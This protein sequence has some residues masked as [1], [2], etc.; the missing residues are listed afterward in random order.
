MSRLACP[1]RDELSA[2]HLGAL[3]E[4]LLEEIAEHLECCPACEAL[5]D[6]LD[7]TSDPLV[8]SLKNLGDANFA[9]P[10]QTTPSTP[11]LPLPSR[12]GGY[13]ILEESGRGGMGVVY[14]AWHSE[15]H[16]VVALKMLHGG[17]FAREDYRARFRAEAESFARLQHP[18]I[19]QIFDIGE[20]MPPGGTAPLP[21]F[22]LEYVDGGNLSTRLDGKPQRPELAAQWLLTLAR[23]V[24]HAHSQGILH[25][26]LKPS[27]VLLTA[28]GQLKLCDFGVAKQ[29]SGSDL[30]T[31]GGLLVGT[32]E[33]MAPE[34]ADGRVED[35]GPASDVYALGAILYMTLTGRPPFQSSSVL[36]LLDQV[37][38]REPVP[39]RRLQPTVPR[40]LETICL[41]CLNKDPKRRYPSASDLAEDLE[42]FLSGRTILARP[43]G[44][45][46]TTWKWARRRPAVAAL[47]SAVVLVTVLGFALVFWKWREAN[48]ANAQAQLARF[49]SIDQQA[50]LALSQGLALCDRGEVEHGL[51]WLSRSQELAD[52]AGN[53]TLDRAIRINLAD[54]AGQL[55]RPRLS[56]RHSASILC[57]AF[58]AD[59][60]TLY[61]AGKDHNI[62]TWNT[63]TGQESAPPMVLDDL[64]E[65]QWVGRIA[66]NPKDPH[67]LATF[68]EEGRA[69]FWD[70]ER[71][72]P[73]GAPL[74]HP[75]GHMIWGA[76]FTPDG[77]RLVTTCD[78]GAA[79][80]WDVA[81]HKL[82]GE[83]LWHGA[84]VGY[85]T[86]AVSPD[87]NM[88]VTGGKD[89]R[90]LRWNL[91][92]GE[93][94]E[95]S[96]PHSS[97]VHMIAFSQDG[98]RIITGTRDGGL[99]VWNAQTARVSDLPP[100]GTSVTSLAVSS[101]GRTFATGTAGGVVRLW[102]TTMLGPIGQTYKLVTAVTGLAFAPDGSTLAIGQEDG[103][104]RIWEAPRPKALGAPLTTLSAVR[105]LA[106]SPDGGRLLTASTKGAQWW[107]LVS[108]QPLSPLMT[109]ERYDGGGTVSSPDGRRTYEVVNMV[110][111]TAF[112]PNGLT[113]AMARWDGNERHVRGRAEIWDTG[114]AERLRQ[115][116]EQPLPLAGVAYSPDSKRLLTWDSQPQSALLWDV[117]SLQTPR[118]LAR[119]LTAPI[120]QAAFSPDGKSLLLACLDGTARL[121]DIGQD[122]ETSLHYHAQHGY[123]VT[124]VAFNA[125]GTRFVT[126][127][128]DGTVR[129]WNAF[130][131][132]RL[133]DLRG[134]A[135]EVVAVAFN[136]D[137]STLLTACHDGTARFW[138]VESGRQLGPPL[139]HT[140]AVL[141]IVFDPD[142]KSI[143]TGTKDGLV[144]RWATPAR[145]KS[146]SIAEIRDWVE[147]QTGLALDDQGEVHTLVI[148]PR[149][150]ESE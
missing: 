112:S 40:D 39:L 11:P 146:G 25:R 120:H 97:P 128:Q 49:K 133:R 24:Q 109:S 138:D 17:E 66:L 107:G 75:P 126:G 143:A 16:R 89:L 124:A 63:K 127:C 115:S 110:E 83:P 64:R 104:I 58:S 119:T 7:R 148:E 57:L 81:T 72:Q 28:D 117:S 80:S 84:E 87:G 113:L 98:Q 77:K 37:R 85:Y 67:M 1:T 54:W 59:G 118:P 101:D 103:T 30:K 149:K 29:L 69:Q 93:W 142:G 114:T 5:V 123:P 99:H 20:W 132:T 45:W 78:D 27:N 61:S 65:D 90:G 56:C 51:L 60:R 131:G 14:K 105:S 108:G 46:E 6:A 86:L 82:I 21:Y 122:T 116:P 140:D 76:A 44:A 13:E 100:Q 36:N 22:T 52:E 18:N 19:I 94:I 92:T 130:D 147:R 129:L 71:R 135:G 12:I 125:P 96:L 136:A 134:N 34:Q 150:Q 48:A 121:W 4:S 74:I 55:S 95:P 35:S 38:T 31:Q 26:D 91:K 2:F 53:K 9:L 42:R 141:S 88:L 102:D 43:A 47:S 145:P 41:K 33:F 79:R 3:T 32:P 139:R 144:Q 68:D 8:D 106:F 15:L 70:L 62:R 137:G 73:I 111:A 10:L 50:E 23:A